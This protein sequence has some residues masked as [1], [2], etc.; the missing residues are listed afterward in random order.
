MFVGGELM[1]SGAAHGLLAVRRYDRC[2]PSLGVV[3]MEHV[4]ATFRW[5]TLLHTADQRGPGIEPRLGHPL[6]QT[7]LPVSFPHLF[8]PWHWWSRVWRWEE[9][10]AFARRSDGPLVPRVRGTASPEGL[11]NAL[12]GLRISS[13]HKHPILGALCRPGTVPLGEL[14]LGRPL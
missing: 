10:G 4:Y 12:L 8:L 3:L 9:T 6:A 13:R 11:W 14:G 5:G 2:C 1:L 7:A